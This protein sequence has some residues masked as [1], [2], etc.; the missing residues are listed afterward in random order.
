MIIKYFAN[1]G[2]EFDDKLE[3]VNYEKGQLLR[4]EKISKG[5]YMWDKH[6]EILTVNEF[7]R[8]WY[9]FI[10]DRETIEAFEGIIF[11]GVFPCE[12]GAWYY[13]P[14][15]DEFENLEEKINNMK[16]E[17]QTAEDFIFK[18]IVATKAS[19]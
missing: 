14:C 15:N 2:T 13:N 7:E 12:V 3:C 5:L 9:V 8:A 1:D 16:L 10:K 17:L 6:G 11:G 4:N 18:A 19:F